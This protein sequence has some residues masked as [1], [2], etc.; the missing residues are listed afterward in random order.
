MRLIG[1]PKLEEFW[2]RHADS[3]QQLLAWL[4]D[5]ED[6]EW[7]SGHE[8]AETY[9]NVRIIPPNRA[10]FNIKGNRYRLVVMIN[11]SIKSVSI[12]FV[13]THAQ[14]DRIDVETI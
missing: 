14:Y 9:S 4:N 6:S 3:K 10:L 7:K 11:Y 5:A 1:R 8:L 12:R 13:G 2:K